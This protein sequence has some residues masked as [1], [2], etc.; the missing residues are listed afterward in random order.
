MHHYKIKPKIGIGDVKFE[1]HRIKSDT[2]PY[3]SIWAHIKTGKSDMAQ[4]HF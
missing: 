1:H 4:N 2:S 3:G